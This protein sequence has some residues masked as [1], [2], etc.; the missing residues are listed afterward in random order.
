MTVVRPC[1]QTHL[2]MENTA[3]IEQ[4]EPKDDNLAKVTDWIDRPGK[5]VLHT[6]ANVDADA[7]F[8]AA[9]MLFMRE[10]QHGPDSTDLSFL[11][12]DATVDAED[13][14]AVDMMNGSSAIKGIDTG[15]AFG[16]LVS[17]LVKAE[18]IPY[19]LYKNFAEQLN[20]TD[21]G[22]RCN[23]R[24]ALAGLVKSWTYSGLCDREIVSRAREILEGMMKGMV[25]HRRRR[26]VSSRMPIHDG[27]ALNLSG[28]GLDRRTLS[29]RGA[30]LVINQH[31][32]IGQSV[33]L[34]SRGTRAELDLNDLSG[35]LPERWFIH[36]NGFIACYGSMK[37]KKNPEDSG[38][39]LA[40]LCKEVH[41]WLIGT[42][43]FTPDEVLL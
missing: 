31:E 20:L 35:A 21:S 27:V 8:S 38:I 25:K 26:I 24:V 4:V 5:A 18:L 29:R 13:A 41:D 14:L 39:T 12:T 40:T 34:T 43:G 37:G 33:V 10:R 11:P 16:E 15:S 36:P 42:L 2:V 28:G 1:R 7:A 23:D 32:D 30:F 9:L 3:T 22:K 19:R 17:I 6:H